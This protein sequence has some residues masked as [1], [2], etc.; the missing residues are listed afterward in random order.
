MLT[1]N[2]IHHRDVQSPQ[3]LRCPVAGRLARSV[4]SSAP[5]P[6]VAKVTKPALVKMHDRIPAPDAT[7]HP[8]AY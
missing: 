1:L 8:V 6:R 5:N 4:A 2:P 3:T 7:E